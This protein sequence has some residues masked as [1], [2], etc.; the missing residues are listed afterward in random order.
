ML[1][2]IVMF[3]ATGCIAPEITLFEI[4]TTAEETD[5]PE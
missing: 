2:G 1:L 4:K 5:V 3:T